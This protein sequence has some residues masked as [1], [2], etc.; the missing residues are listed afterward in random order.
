MAEQHLDLDFWTSRED[1]PLLAWPERAENPLHSERIPR[2][3]QFVQF[4]ELATALHKSAKPPFSAPSRTSFDLLP[5]QSHLLCHH[6][7]FNRQVATSHYSR[8]GRYDVSSRASQHFGR[9]GTA[10]RSRTCERWNDM[11]SEDFNG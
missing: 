9:S 8:L 11:A 4:H 6:Q 5:N 2:Q 10:N 7:D 1:H 3:P